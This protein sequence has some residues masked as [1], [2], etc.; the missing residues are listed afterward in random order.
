MSGLRLRD[1]PGCW[2]AQAHHA[3]GLRGSRPTDTKQ[4]PTFRVV[5]DLNLRTQHEHREPF[6]QTRNE[7]LRC[8]QHD[9]IGLAPGDQSREQ[10]AFRR[11]VA[12]QMPG[13][14][15]QV[16]KVVRKLRVQETQGVRTFCAKDPEVGYRRN[17]TFAKTVGR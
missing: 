9:R 3:H 2:P 6:F 13:G 7:R 15:R 10:A 17:P 11:A 5:G 4:S 1:R 14:R 8:D 12:G 16:F